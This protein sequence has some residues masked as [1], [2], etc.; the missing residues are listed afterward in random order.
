[1]AEE[2]RNLAARSA[3]AVKETT[4]LIENSIHKVEEGYAIANKT[5]EA[6]NKIVTGVSDAVEIV[7]QISE[8][9]VQQATS[10]S[11]IDAGIG[12]ISKVTQSNTATAEESA[13]ASEEM[14]GQAQM[15][16]GMIQ[17]FH[18]KEAQNKSTFKLTGSVAVPEQKK[19]EISLD[20]GDFGK[21]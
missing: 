1:V 15:L 8:A 11:Q 7:E 10:I 9:S 17:E 13:A 21:Y 20:D 3:A 6:L 5:A 18:L 14:A 4:D 2:V 12:Q 19:I 16:K